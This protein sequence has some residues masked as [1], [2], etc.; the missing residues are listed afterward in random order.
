[1]CTLRRNAHA[2]WTITM[3]AVGWLCCLP[4]LVRA[5]SVGSQR[6]G[7]NEATAALETALQL[8]QAV[9]DR[10]GWPVLADDSRLK[11]GARDLRVLALR[12][13]L[14]AEGYPIGE[15]QAD[16][17]LYEGD[18]ELAIGR[19]QALH[20][21]E[22]DGI[23]GAATLA[24]LN[25]SAA[26]RIKQIK[27]N[28]ERRRSLPDSQNERY[29]IVNSAAFHLD[30]V[31]GGRS[32]LHLRTI[33]GRPDWPTPVVS[34]RISAVVFRPLWRV[35]R[36]IAAREVLPL[37]R[38]DSSYLR[39][40]E[41]RIQ[42]SDGGEV[43]PASIAWAAANAETFRFRFVQEPGPSN[44]LGGIK[45]FFRSPF[46]V[47]LHDTPARRLFAQRVRTFSHG[48]VRVEHVERLAA[49]LLPE[50]PMDS[51]HSAMRTGRERWVPLIAPI[52]VHLVYWTA[53]SE[54]EGP[55]AFRDDVYHLDG[56]EP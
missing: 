53:W 40:T 24:A 4:A 7:F 25:V 21:L 42:D 33:V 9:A 43:D 26:A 5:S 34:S 18:L 41:T 48:C 28:L 3:T 35:P 11:P 12:A 39:R 13:R 1:M 45:L 37:V 15:S 31:E 6:A 44:P 36:S 14:Q 19:F 55:V 52:P 10:G 27:T 16:A 23:V 51:I 8:Y 22:E 47:Y 49:Y 38:R 30:V 56:T 20:G 50:W 17:D 29:I 46:D 32:V 2:R 54:G